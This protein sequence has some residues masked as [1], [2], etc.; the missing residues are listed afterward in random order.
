MVEFANTIKTLKKDLVASVDGNTK[1]LNKVL[2]S[3]IEDNGLPIC[4]LDRSEPTFQDSL[5]RISG[6]ADYAVITH[7]DYR[8]EAETLYP[9]EL[10]FTTLEIKGLQFNHVIVYLPFGRQDDQ[11]HQVYAQLNNMLKS[12]DADVAKKSSLNEEEVAELLNPLIVNITRTLHSLWLVQPNS[13]KLA[14]LLEKVGYAEGLRHPITLTLSAATLEDWQKLCEQLL[15]KGKEQRAQ[16][17]YDKHLQGKL[18][19]F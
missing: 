8:T 15:V 19:D 18:Q 11:V 1:G 2:S 5:Q 13:P 10:V 7:E 12:L 9:P 6:S 14:T 17:I 16:L 4:W 3:A